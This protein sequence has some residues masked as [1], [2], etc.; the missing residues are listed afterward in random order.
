[1]NPHQRWTQTDLNDLRARLGAGE[2]PAEVAA[3]VGRTAEGVLAMMSRLRMKAR[4]R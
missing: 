2:Q 1:M 3:A 4:P